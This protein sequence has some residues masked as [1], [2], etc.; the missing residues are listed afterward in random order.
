MPPK[1][2]YEDTW[3]GRRSRQKEENARKKE[4]KEREKQERADLF[5]RG[6]CKGP[7]G[8]I[9]GIAQVGRKFGHLGAEDGTKG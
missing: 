7:D 3:R 6:L 9:Y 4:A 1:K 8:N 5:S 2:N